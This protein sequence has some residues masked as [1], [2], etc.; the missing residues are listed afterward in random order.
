M[1]ENLEGDLG[2]KALFNCISW[3]AS[4]LHFVAVSWLSS[5][6]P[7]LQLQFTIAH[8]VLCCDL[9]AESIVLALQGQWKRRVVG[10]LKC[11]QVI[12][13]WRRKVLSNFEYFQII[14]TNHLSFAIEFKFDLTC[15]NIGPPVSQTKE[16]PELALCWSMIAFIA[17][18]EKKYVSCTCIG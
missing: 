1:A 14:R 10:A 9:V 17:L 15:I 12:W 11:Y 2:E 7:L 3:M 18:L 16:L 5:H 4:T 8:L 6:C 13:R